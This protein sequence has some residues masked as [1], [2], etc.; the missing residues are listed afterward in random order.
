MKLEE[1]IIRAITESAHDVFST[2]L[3]AE[4]GPG[5]ACVEATKP[6]P[7]D[8]VVAL[9]GVAGPW[10]GTGILSCSP[11]LACRM[12]AQMLMTESSS[13]NEE[14]LDALAELTNMIIGGA[15]TALELELGPLGLSIPTVV[16][17]KNFKTKSAMHIQWVVVRFR[18]DDEPFEVKL[19]LTQTGKPHVAAHSGSTIGCG[20]E[21]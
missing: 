21:I 4:L 1:S 6:E 13:I 9:I 10:T 3:G 8:G 11:K 19:C 14:V 7:N 17:G 20:M 18:W 15:K 16:Y 5:E 12:C 2:M